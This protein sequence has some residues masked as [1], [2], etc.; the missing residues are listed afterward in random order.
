ME[1]AGYAKGFSCTLTTEQYEEI[2]NL[3]QIIQ[4]S[5]KAIDI[6]MKLDIISVDVYFAGT[7]TGPPKGWGD[8]PWLNGAITITN[9]GA[10]PV[11]NTLLTAPL[12]SKGVW[13]ASHY[14]NPT[15]DG[16]IKSYLSSPVLKDQQKDV[17]AMQKILLHDTP[18]IIPY[19]YDFTSAG[20]KAVKGFKAD[21]IGL[22]YLSKT[23]LA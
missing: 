3:A 7:Q 5:V 11:P 10:R 20:T 18:E 17:V 23:S 21:E 9:W 6:D 15:F 1:A 22:V 2:P 8:T 12:E 14:S 19:F 16:L 4:N 13:N